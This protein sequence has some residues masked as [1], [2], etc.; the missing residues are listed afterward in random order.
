MKQ[1]SGIILAICG[2]LMMVSNVARPPETP[3]KDESARVRSEGLAQKVG[4][5]AIAV[6]FLAGGLKLAQEPK[7]PSLSPPFPT[8]LQSPPMQPPG[9]DLAAS[10]PPP[11]SGPGLVD[12]VNHPSAPGGEG[13]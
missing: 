7:R 2:V 10:P 4:S 12:E 11:P 1:T 8:C 9:A 5:W 6:L 3:G 13:R